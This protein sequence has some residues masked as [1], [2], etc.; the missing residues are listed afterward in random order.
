M[1]IYWSLLENF[2]GSKL[3]L[4]KY[5]DEILEHFQREFPDF[6]LKATINENDM[7]SKEGKEHWRKFIMTYEKR[8]ED[9]NFGAMIRANAATEYGQDEV[10]FGKLHSGSPPD[11][12]IRLMT[13]LY[14]RANAILC[15]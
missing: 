6:D 5:D 2:Q 3:K 9:Y 4:T 15:D 11:G 8:I 7:K 14:S 10:I 13:F 1:E 12:I